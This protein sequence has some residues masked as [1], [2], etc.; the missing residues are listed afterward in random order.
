MII[1]IGRQKVRQKLIM[2]FYPALQSQGIFI[3]PPSP[4]KQKSPQTLLFPTECRPL[5][6]QNIQ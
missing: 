4:Q 5:H 3:P 6:I 1:D 2:S